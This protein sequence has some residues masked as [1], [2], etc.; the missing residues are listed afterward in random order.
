MN[1]LKIIVALLMMGLL[2]SCILNTSQR[3]SYNH[4]TGDL[5]TE[6]IDLRSQKGRNDKDYSIEKDWEE[7]KQMLHS[8]DSEHDENV[9]DLINRELYQDGDVLSGRITWRVRCPDCFPGVIDVMRYLHKGEE[10]SY[11]FEDIRG[12]MFLF[13]PKGRRVIETNGEVLETSKNWVIV[14]PGDAELIEFTIRGEHTGGKSLL[15]FF[16]NDEEL[17]P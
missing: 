4:K 16:L 6:W 5:V 8:D 11:R 9:V 14:W 17:N 2:S 15:P 12:D 1:W 13:L 3:F 7:L 10:K